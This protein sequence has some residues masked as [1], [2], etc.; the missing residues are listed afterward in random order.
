M[1]A[2]WLTRLLQD[3]AP[4]GAAAKKRKP[5]AA[6]PAAA[7]KAAKAAK[8]AKNPAEAGGGKDAK[9]AKDAPTRP[10]SVS[11]LDLL[12]AGL[13][14]PG[15]GV[16]VSTYG[17]V[18]HC[19]DLGPAGVL[20]FRGDFFANLSSWTLHVKRLTNPERK[21]DD[22]WKC[23]M[24]QGELLDTLKKRLQAQRLNDSTADAH[25]YAA[26]GAP[27]AAPAMAAVAAPAAAAFP[28]L[29]RGPASPQLDAPLPPRELTDYV[30]QRPKRERHAPVRLASS[31]GGDSEEGDLLMVSCEPYASDL[32]AAQ[33][34]QGALDDVAPF[35]VRVSSSAALLMDAHAHLST[36]EVIGFLGGTWERHSRIVRV[37]RAMPAGQL[38]SG[39]GAVEVELDPSSMPAILGAFEA[40]GLQVVG[41]YHSHPVFATQPSVRDVANQGAYQNMFQVRVTP[42]QR[43]ACADQRPRARHSWAQSWGPTTRDCPTRNPTFVGAP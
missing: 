33:A 22:G 2:E 6:R 35:S 25:A 15:A 16:L 23:T 11:L 28:P 40:E 1:C 43:C 13:L 4:S 24:Y 3:Y 10:P 8:A 36:A 9:D 20:H 26:T 34:S 31:A 32:A 5:A 27:T 17:G 37:V 7:P 14:R 42:L 18:T 38:V 21:A 12:R 39:D 30:R 41:W 29:S 19:A